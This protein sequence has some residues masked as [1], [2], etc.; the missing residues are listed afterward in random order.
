MDIHL[1]F[2]CSIQ[3]DSSV[4]FVCVISNICL[5]FT[6]NIHWTSIVI[7]CKLVDNSIIEALHNFEGHFLSILTLISDLNRQVVW[8]YIDHLL[9]LSTNLGS[10]SNSAN[11]LFFSLV[12]ARSRSRS[13][14]SGSRSGPRS[15][16]RCGTRSRV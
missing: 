2:S 1:H 16:F 15:G 8:I 7:Q 14:S 13:G 12:N 5:H 6:S 3:A 4:S 10:I 11:Q 9:L